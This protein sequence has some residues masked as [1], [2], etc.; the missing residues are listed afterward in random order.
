MPGRGGHCLRVLAACWVT[1]GTMWERQEQT[2]LL[3]ELEPRWRLREGPDR[4]PGPSVCGT[5]APNLGSA[6]R[7]AFCPTV[8]ALQ[9]LLGDRTVAPCHV[10]GPIPVAGL[11]PGSVTVCRG[12]TERS[13]PP[14]PSRLP[15]SV[16]HH[17]SFHRLQGEWTS[18]SGTGAGGCAALAVVTAPEHIVQGHQALP[19]CC[20]NI[21]AVTSGTFSTAETGSPS[22]LN[23]HSRPRPLLLS[24]R[25]RV[26]AAVAWSMS[27]GSLQD[28]PQLPPPP[29]R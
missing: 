3:G 6:G 9:G 21:T 16:I 20:A 28:T 26:G 29:P 12:R 4:V 22:P 10:P 19:R 17:V 24:P 13:L 18:R 1:L 11:S 7:T 8:P 25:D 27:L 23:T 5:G 14:G 2:L 15:W